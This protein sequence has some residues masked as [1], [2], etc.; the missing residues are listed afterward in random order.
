MHRQR[1]MSR[2]L[3]IAFL[4]AVPASAQALEGTL[5]AIK[6]RKAMVIGYLKDA[7]PMSFEGPNGPD[8]YS[9]E[10]C[11]R[12]ADE[13]GKATGIEKLE[14]RYVPVT[15]ENRFDAVASGKVDIEC[16]TTTAT[17]SRMQKVDFT[18]LIFADAGSL[19]VKKGSPIRN[20]AALVD[21]SVAVVPGTTTE[22]ALRNAIS[23]SLIRAKVVDVPDHAAGIAAVQTGKVSA[24]ASDRIILA[25]LL[26]KPPGAGLD[27]VPMQFSFEPYGLMVRRGDADFRLV[28]NR[29]LSR[30]Y[31]SND[32]A[33]IFERWFGAMGKPGD[34][35]VLMYALN[36][37]PE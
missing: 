4:F 24:Y 20:L 30:V 27:L 9:V 12:V 1:Q 19:A 26:V 23:Q 15:L 13:A 16:G 14:V 22:K 36:A 2:T 21:E 25:G 11:R 34:V 7:Y 8:G 37:T 5:K 18:N 17:L 35:L 33:N 29:A 32:I 28:A 10:L 3:L 31:R 6:E